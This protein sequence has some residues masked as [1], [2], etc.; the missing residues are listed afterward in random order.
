VLHRLTAWESRLLTRERKA[1]F[2]RTNI[3]CWQ[4]VMCKQSSL[5]ELLTSRQKSERSRQGLISRH[6]TVDASLHAWLTLRVGRDA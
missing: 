4:T 6:G 2:Q 3:N 1:G 5:P